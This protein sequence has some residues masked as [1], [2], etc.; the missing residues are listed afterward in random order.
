MTRSERVVVLEHEVPSVVAVGAPVRDDVTRLEPLLGL[1]AD[2]VAG[3][4]AVDA[5]D[6]LRCLHGSDRS[7]I[8]PA[9]RV[10]AGT[11]R[12]R[13]LVAPRGDTTRPTSDRVREAI[14]N[15]L[16]SL[17]DVVH[18]ARVLDLFAGSGALGIEAL[19]RGATSV[20]FVERGRPAL[21]AI[22]QNLRTLGL[23]P[24]AEVVAAEALDW[25]RRAPGEYDLVLCDPPYDYD[26]WP[27]LLGLLVN[28]VPAGFV[29]LESDRA[30]DFGEEWD[31]IRVR[32]YGATVVSI[33][34]RR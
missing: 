18:G 24:Q 6:G 22:R 32:R 2:A 13:A 29:V 23:E 21:A 14:F 11:A 27:A 15:A 20:T 3:A 7:C 1:V 8:L 5:H 19:S 34:Q 12:G 25:L 10:V 30:I 31:A 28:T 17:G 26:E 9:M 33:V 16:Y 4:A